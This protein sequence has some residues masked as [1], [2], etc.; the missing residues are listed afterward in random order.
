MNYLMKQSNGITQNRNGKTIREKYANQIL[1][2][3]SNIQSNEQVNLDEEYDKDKFESLI[4]SMEEKVDL[5]FKNR[6]TE[7]GDRVALNKYAEF[8]Q[9][10]DI[11][12]SSI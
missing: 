12:S 1:L 11:K 5:G 6:N 2:Y 9:C 7:N 4:F 3:L 10:H 8:R